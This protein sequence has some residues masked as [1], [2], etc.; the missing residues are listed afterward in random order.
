MQTVIFY[1]KEQCSLCDDALAFLYM[2]KK[3]YSFDIQ[4]RDI[5]SNDEWLEKYQLL[6]PVIEVNGE[7]LNC[8][9]MRYEDIEHFLKKNC[10]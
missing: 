9:Q 7:Q 1:T 2:F 10:T 5:Y 4:C 6:I 8:E 3:D